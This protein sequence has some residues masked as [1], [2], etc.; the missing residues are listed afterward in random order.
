MRKILYTF[1]FVTILIA[2]INIVKANENAYFTNREGIEMTEVE[3]HNLLELGFTDKQIDRMDY[4]TYI[5]NKDIEATLVSEATNYYKT[6]TY[7]RNGI[8]YQTSELLTKEEMDEI[9]KNKQEQ[10]PQ[11]DN[12]RT[13]GN[14][15]NGLFADDYK[16]VTTRIAYIDDNNV[17]RFKTDTYWFQMPSQRSYDI[18]GIG[19]EPSKVEIDAAIIFRQDWQTTG[20]TYGSSTACAPKEQTTGGSVLFQ[21]P[22]G[23]LSTLESSIYFDVSKKSGVG[24]ISSL[25]ATGDYAH[26]IVSVSNNAYYYYSVNHGTG[27]VVSNPYANSYDSI[28]PAQAAFSGT[29]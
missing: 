21:L 28:V 22:S 5:N 1:L 9:L 20:G 27:I 15:Y 4:T 13:S 18:V 6:T 14:Y 26:A 7:F 16:A 19:I 23:S 25:Y 3:Y 2:N 17:M 10:N 24:T 29:W 12:T 11:V 8:Q